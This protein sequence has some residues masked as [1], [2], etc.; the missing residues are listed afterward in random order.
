M[1]ALAVVGGEGGR[2]LELRARL[3]PPAQ[4]GE[5]VAPDRGQQVVAAQG[6]V[7][8]EARAG[9]VALSAMATATAR[10]SSMTGDGLSPPRVS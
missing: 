2:P 9:P 5:Q 3:I 4:P 6:R 8:R 10:L 7:A 1:G